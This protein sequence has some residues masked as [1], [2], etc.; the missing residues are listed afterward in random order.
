[1]SVRLDPSVNDQ[2]CRDRLVGGA[3]A[4]FVDRRPPGWQSLRSAGTRMMKG[5]NFMSTRTS[6]CPVF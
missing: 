1:M 2:N 5:E 3:S 6:T 4:K